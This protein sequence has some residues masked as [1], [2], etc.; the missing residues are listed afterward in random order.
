M[1]TPTIHTLKMS[2]RKAS[3]TTTA[4]ALMERLSDS[5]NQ[6][7]NGVVDEA[8]SIS[9]GS[10]KK[11]QSKTSPDEIK[12]LIRKNLTDRLKKKL[13][14]NP[15]HGPLSVR[16]GPLKCTVERNPTGFVPITD[17]WVLKRINDCLLSSS[18]DIPKEYKTT[19]DVQKL[20][21]LMFAPEH[22]KMKRESFKFT[23]KGEDLKLAGVEV[24]SDSDAESGS[25]DDEESVA[26]SDGEGDEDGEETTHRAK[27]RRVSKTEEGKKE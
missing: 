7:K 13:L 12:K 8:G 18:N 2:K 6:N 19:E 1:T 24:S 26:S 17:E 20:F 14:V 21:E 25:N 22:R 10:K 27:R 3:N 16:Y 9:G 23:S 15:N 4:K 11:G 5:L